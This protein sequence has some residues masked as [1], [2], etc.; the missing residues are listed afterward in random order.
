[1]LVVADGSGRAQGVVHESQLLRDI[2][3]AALTH[4]QSRRL[5]WDATALD[6]ISSF[7]SATAT[8]VET[9]PLREALVKMANTQER[10]LLVVDEEGFP[11]GL[12]FDVDCLPSQSNVPSM[13]ADRTAT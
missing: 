1:M 6:P 12:L 13:T 5:G 9:M 11:I 2:E 7:T 10:Q 4:P 3:P 8:V